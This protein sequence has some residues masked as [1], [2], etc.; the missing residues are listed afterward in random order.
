METRNCILIGNIVISGRPIAEVLREITDKML[1]DPEGTNRLEGCIADLRKLQGIYREE[2]KGREHFQ[3]R[4]EGRSVS[5]L[6]TD[7]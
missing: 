5:K 3:V 6:P 2:F 1:T 4:T 7:N